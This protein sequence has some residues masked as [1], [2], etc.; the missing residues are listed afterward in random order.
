M[1][2]FTLVSFLLHPIQFVR[3]RKSS[4]IDSAREISREYAQQPVAHRIK[5]RVRPADELPKP[6]G[7]PRPEGRL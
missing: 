7:A 5:A 1:A 2:V 3:D 6:P 4:R